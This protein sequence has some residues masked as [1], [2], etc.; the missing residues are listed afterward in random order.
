MPAGGTP[1]DPD[2]VARHLVSQWEARE[3]ALQEGHT[4]RLRELNEEERAFVERVKATL[5]D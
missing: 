5:E 3:M 2:T 1:P 4:V